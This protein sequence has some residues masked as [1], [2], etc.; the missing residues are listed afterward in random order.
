MPT[1]IDLHTHTTCSDGA[2]TPVDLVH[3][4][5]ERGIVALSI[6]DHDTAQAAREL[7]SELA[8]QAD[9]EMVAGIEISA[10]DATQGKEYHI[11]GYYFDAHHPDMLRYESYCR[12][13]RLRRAE[14]I[15]ERLHDKGVP[16]TME[17]VLRRAAAG[18]LGRQHI[19]LALCEEGYT[20]TTKQAFTKYLA[21]DRPAFVEKWHFSVQEAIDLIH[22]AGGVAVLAHPARTIH[23]LA[24][25]NMVKS[26]LDGI[27]VVHPAHDPALRRS[28]EQFAKGY[29]LLMTGGSDYHGNKYGD[30]N[31]FGKTGIPREYYAALQRSRQAE[32]ADW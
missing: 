23:G 2:L 5:R 26:G 11:L 27:E 19:A 6:T 13:E 31:H 22:T 4:A 29:R 28:Y 21:N 15:V 24:L 25:V 10:F 16:L 18:V 32:C 9:V 12:E 14:R 30:E 7:P 1:I 3:K 17:A 8:L 20:H